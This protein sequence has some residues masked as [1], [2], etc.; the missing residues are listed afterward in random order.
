V[1]VCTFVPRR[2]PRQQHKIQRTGA[3]RGECPVHHKSTHILQLR[4]PIHCRVLLPTLPPLAA[5]VYVCARIYIYIC[6]CVKCSGTC[7][8]HTFCRFV[9]PHIVELRRT[10]VVHP[11]GQTRLTTVAHPDGR[12]PF[13]CFYVHRERKHTRTFIY[14]H[15][16]YTHT[17]LYIYMCVC[18]HHLSTCTQKPEPRLIR[19]IHTRIHIYV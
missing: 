13:R 19:R 7:S 1:C 4:Q 10:T 17:H 8:Q 14:M 5:C 3:A 16:T 9:S 18:V 11:D 6:V 15:N 12:I 2:D